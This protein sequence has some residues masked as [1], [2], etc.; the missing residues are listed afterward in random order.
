MLRPTERRSVLL[1]DMFEPV[2][3]EHRSRRSDGDVIGDAAV[4]GDER[5]TDSRGRHLADG[6]N[7]GNG[8]L[9][10]I[11]AHGSELRERVEFAERGKPA[12]HARAVHLS[13]ALEREEHVKV[14]ERERLHWKVQNR[15]TAPQL[16]K[17]KDAIQLAH[18]HGGGMPVRGQAFENRL[19]PRGA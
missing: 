3:E 7:L 1:P 9:W 18:A 2:I 11:P 13:P 6:A 14:P 10:V 4:V 12:A 8:P 5:M 17:A 15:R 19:Q 16:G